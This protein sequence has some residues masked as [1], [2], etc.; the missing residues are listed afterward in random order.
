MDRAERDMWLCRYATMVYTDKPDGTADE[1]EY[2]LYDGACGPVLAVRGTE[3]REMRDVARDLAV[4][5]VDHPFL[6]P[7]HAGFADGVDDLLDM[8]VASDLP[9]SL[10]L[11]GHS[12]GAI[13]SLMLA[14]R[15]RQIGH[16][17]EWVGFGCPKG[18]IGPRSLGFPA[19]AYV[20][21]SDLVT[22]IPP[23]VFL[24][25]QHPSGM[26]VVQ[27]GERGW[28]PNLVDHR[29]A[30]YLKSMMTHR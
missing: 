8:L 21:G 12:L 15:L 19:R 5:K 20:N 7:V 22:M 2:K 30:N 26:E 29:T 1:L 27:I 24:D 25:Y 13:T 16:Y 3:I 28:R 11:T 10:T 9:Y 4:W 18:F 23:G 17:V 6:G 14:V